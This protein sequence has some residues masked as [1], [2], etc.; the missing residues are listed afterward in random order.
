MLDPA[1]VGFISREEA[2]AQASCLTE[3]CKRRQL[4]GLN[5]WLLYIDLAK[6]YDSVPHEAL[7]MK[8]QRFGIHG[9]ALNWLKAIY[10]KPKLC[11]RTAGG[12]SEEKNYSRG[13]RTR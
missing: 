10:S 5:T 8:A 1:Q 2:V 9:R 7:I 11:C 6:A 4:M 3:I 12:Y 13:V